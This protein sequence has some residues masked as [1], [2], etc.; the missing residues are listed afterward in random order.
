[1]LTEETGGSATSKS[2]KIS[3]QPVFYGTPYCSKDCILAAA[4]QHEE[5]ESLHEENGGPGFVGF[6][7]PPVRLSDSLLYF[8]S[9]THEAFPVGR[10]PDAGH[11]HKSKGNEGE[12]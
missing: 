2:S 3:S 8:L 7:P 9:P 12:R 5:E 6:W 4:A 1:M 10:F 11:S